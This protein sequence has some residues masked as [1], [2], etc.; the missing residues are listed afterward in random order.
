MIFSVVFCVL[1]LFGWIGAGLI[2]V[3]FIHNEKSSRFKPSDIYFPKRT[4]IRWNKRK[5][6][7]RGEK[8]FYQC[9]NCQKSLPSQTIEELACGCGN[10]F[11]G[12]EHIGAESPMKVRLYEE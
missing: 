1:V 7:P 10:L 3:Y 12:P 11:V 8:L 5:Q 6:W 9:L 4:T 2:G